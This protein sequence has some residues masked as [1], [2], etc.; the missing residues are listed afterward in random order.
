MRPDYVVEVFLRKFRVVTYPKVKYFPNTIEMSIFCSRSDTIGELKYRICNSHE[1]D[2]STNKVV[3]ELMDLCRLW[4]LE[5][6]E[7]V[8]DVFDSLDGD[9]YPNAVN[10][11]VLDPFMLVC[12][13]N[14]ADDECLILE[15]K[16]NIDANAKSPW[17]YDPKPNNRRNRFEKESRLPED[18]KAIRD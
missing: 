11:R 10:G 6:D 17:V 3:T 7:T 18:L 8:Q 16:I 1:F 12:D 9:N 14:I 15:W 5:G 13:A 4:K 2:Q